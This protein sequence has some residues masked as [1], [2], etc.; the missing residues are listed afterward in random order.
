MAPPANEATPPPIHIPHENDDIHHPPPPSIL[1]LLRTALSHADQRIA[2][3][4]NYSTS[5]NAVNVGIVLPVLKYSLVHTSSNHTQHEAMTGDYDTNYHHHHRREEDSSGEHDSL[6]AS[7]L[8][9]GMI[10][11]QLLGG[12]LGD[13]IGRRHAMMVVMMLQIV[14]SLG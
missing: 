8:L 10:C 2:M 3:L 4:S 11:G 13:V 5:Y 14:G 9:A 6:V 1:H 7:S 12:Y